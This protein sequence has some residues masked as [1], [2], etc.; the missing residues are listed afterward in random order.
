MLSFDSKRHRAA[1]IP[2]ICPVI[3]LGVMLLFVDRLAGMPLWWKLREDPWRGDGLFEPRN[4][5]SKRLSV[6]V[7]HPSFLSRQAVFCGPSRRRLGANS[8]LTAMNVLRRLVVIFSQIP[9]G[10]FPCRFKFPV[11]DNKKQ[12]LMHHQVC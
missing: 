11:R 9:A 8:R 3:A 10:E 4:R 7:M 1:S 12:L 2:L 6:Q 5:R